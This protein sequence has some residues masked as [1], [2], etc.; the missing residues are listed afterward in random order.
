MS[1]FTR[2]RRSPPLVAFALLA[3]VVRAWVPSG[4]MPAGDGSLRLQICPEGLSVA[5]LAV[6]DPHA[7]HHHHATAGGAG[8]HPHD[9]QSWAAG[10]CAFAALASVLLPSAHASPA[11]LTFDVAFSARSF[12]SFAVP[13]NHRFRISQPRG[14][15]ALI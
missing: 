10:H 2:M 5:A 8:G 7:A 14:P 4:Y 15:P 12:L 6:L 11:E 1:L 13:E 9:H 3:F